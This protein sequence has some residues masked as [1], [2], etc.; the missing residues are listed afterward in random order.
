MALKKL[1]PRQFLTRVAFKSKLSFL[2]DHQYIETHEDDEKIDLK[3]LEAEEEDG[4]AGA[5]EPEPEHPSNMCRICLEAPSTVL[6][7]ICRHMQICDACYLTIYNN[8]KV[9]F[10]EFMQQWFGD[11]DLLDN[12]DIDVPKIIIKCPICREQHLKKDIMIGIYT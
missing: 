2:C 12:N 11:N 10:N 7:M 9:I 1:T 6:F 4:G 8:E 5:G 3:Q